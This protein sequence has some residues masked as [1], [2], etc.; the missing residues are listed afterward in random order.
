MD[1]IHLLQKFYQKIWIWSHSFFLVN[2]FGIF[3]PLIIT[4]IFCKYFFAS[5]R[6]CDFLW[7][8]AQIFSFILRSCLIRNLKTRANLQ[9]LKWI[10]SKF[11]RCKG[12]WGHGLQSNQGPTCKLGTPF[13]I[14][15]SR[16]LTLHMVPTTSN[17]GAETSNDGALRSRGT[18]SRSYDDD[19]RGWNVER[20]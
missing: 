15:I 11:A 16:T 20:T 9:I 1:F 8:S 3:A 19:R 2:I 10:K 7:R 18:K 14:S 5:C 17:S 13:D 4:V 12:K 6:A